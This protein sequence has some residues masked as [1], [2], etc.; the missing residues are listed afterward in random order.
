MYLVGY[1]F[2]GNILLTSN[3]LDEVSGVFLGSPL[4]FVHDADINKFTTES[5]LSKFHEKNRAI[6]EFLGRGY[7]NA[8][9]GIDSDDW[10]KYFMGIDNNSSMEYF[11]SASPIMIYHGTQDRQV[12]YKFSQ[13]F[14]ERYGAKVHL[15]PNESHSK[16][17]IKTDDVIGSF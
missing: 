10:K 4:I 9:R 2:A 11:R 3:A 13:Y 16:E 1:S 8:W 14:S 12:D 7:R 6:I 5:D 17:L 15:V